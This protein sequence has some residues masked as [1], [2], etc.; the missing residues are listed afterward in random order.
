MSTTT[1]VN[2]LVKYIQVVRRFSGLL[3]DDAVGGDGEGGSAVGTDSGEEGGLAEGEGGLAEGEGGLPPL[4]LGFMGEMGPLGPFGLCPV[5]DGG[6]LV[7]PLPAGVV[8]P[9]LM[10]QYRN[11]LVVMA[12]R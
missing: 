3:D 1:N 7:P 2:T 9:P 8:G 10:T 5:G 6:G 11:S 4:P 12:G